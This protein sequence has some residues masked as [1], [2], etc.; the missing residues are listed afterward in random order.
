MFVRALYGDLSAFYAYVVMMSCVV[1][2]WN[3][4]FFF[5]FLERKGNAWGMRAAVAAL[6]Q[7]EVEVFGVD[8]SYR[9]P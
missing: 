9:W 3:F 2:V 4:F 8:T 5:F 7:N 6:P 1:L